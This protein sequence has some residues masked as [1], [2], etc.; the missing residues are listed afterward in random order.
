[1]SS[2]GRRS[3]EPNSGPRSMYISEHGPQGPV[4]P[5]C[6]KFSDARQAHDPLLGDADLA[7]DLDR[8]VSGPRPSSSSPSNTVTQIRSGSKPK[9]SI[10]SSQPKRIDSALK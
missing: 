3:S 6:Q 4:G 1:M 10:E 7:P 8:L 5:A 2:P 9:P